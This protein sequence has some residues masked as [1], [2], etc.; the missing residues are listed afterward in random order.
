M[1]IEAQPRTDG[2]MNVLQVLDV[3][4]ELSH[5]QGFYGRLYETIL[6]TKQ[7]DEAALM[8]SHKLLKHRILKMQSMWYCSLRPNQFSAD[9]AHHVWCV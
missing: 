1:I 8:S 3:I 6:E 7:N 4:R 2:C 9:Q 5:S